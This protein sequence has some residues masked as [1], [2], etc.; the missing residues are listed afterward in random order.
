MRG[1][2]RVNAA[3]AAA[4]AARAPKAPRAAAAHQG[5][6]G[7]AARVRAC[8]VSADAKGSEQSARARSDVSGHPQPRSCARCAC[9]RLRVRLRLRTHVRRKRRAVRAIARRSSDRKRK[10]VRAPPRCWRCFPTPRRGRS[11]RRY[12]LARRRSSRSPRPRHRAHGTRILV[13]DKKH[14]AATEAEAGAEGL[15]LVVRG[16]VKRG[17]G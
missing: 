12:T 17:R 7:A 6:H 4:E 5:P 8:A 14:A 2:G 3:A 9:V 11:H 1:A 16:R 15:A 13:R 10:S